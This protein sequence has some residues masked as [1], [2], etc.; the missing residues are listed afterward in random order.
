MKTLAVCVLTLS[1]FLGSASLLPAEPSPTL[2]ASFPL[3]QNVNGT[4]SIWTD[5]AM[6]LYYP[7]PT[8]VL[9]YDFVTPSE[10]SRTFSWSAA[11]T[12]EFSTLV[13]RM[14]D[15][16]DENINFYEN[17]NWGGNAESVWLT[18]VFGSS[19]SMNGVDLQGFNI[20]RIDMRVDSL[21]LTTPGRD[22]YGDGTW[23]DVGISGE[24]LIYGSPVPEP[25]TFTLLGLGSLA[26]VMARRGR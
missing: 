21:T 11:S 7:N 4:H 3:F 22:L 6:G 10:V 19:L 2:I 25:A 26:L 5:V 18:G 13:A 20:S 14:T 8:P 9:I 15:G 12:P 1:A 23:T 24:F 16:I 17:G